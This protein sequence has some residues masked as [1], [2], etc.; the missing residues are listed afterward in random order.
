[1]PVPE[2]KTIIRPVAPRGF[3]WAVV[4]DGVVVKQGLTATEF[5]A[6]VMATGEVEDLTTAKKNESLD[7][8][9]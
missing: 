9:S 5:E 8:R 2:Y 3:C 7:G 1:M 6:R 4:L